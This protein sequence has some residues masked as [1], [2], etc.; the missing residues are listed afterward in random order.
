MLFPLDCMML[1]KKCTNRVS[2]EVGTET[3][4]Q[5]QCHADQMTRSQEL[6]DFESYN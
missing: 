3:Q 4:T 1:T 5:N 2:P 6:I